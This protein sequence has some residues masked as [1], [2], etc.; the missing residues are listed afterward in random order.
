[1]LLLKNIPNILLVSLKNIICF[2]MQKGTITAY[3]ISEQLL[4]FSFVWQSKPT[5]CVKYG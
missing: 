3:M 5:Y 4:P 1:M 2:A